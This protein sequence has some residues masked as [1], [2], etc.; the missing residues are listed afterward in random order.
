MGVNRRLQQA[1]IGR[2][3]CNV[4]MEAYG[5]F[6]AVAIEHKPECNRVRLRFTY[7]LVSF[8]ECRKAFKVI[9]NV[10]GSDDAL[11]QNKGFWPQTSCWTPLTGPT[12]SFYCCPLVGSCRVPDPPDRVRISSLVPTGHWT[13]LKSYYHP[14][15][16]GPNEMK[17]NCTHAVHCCLIVSLCFYMSVFQR[18]GP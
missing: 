17:L 5:S 13:R 7:S 6:T 4:S 11:E 15:C 3:P 9:L 10:L 1:H 12:T 14:S 16:E 8:F 18:W 2:N